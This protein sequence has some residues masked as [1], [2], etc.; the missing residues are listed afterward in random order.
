MLYTTIV[1]TFGE[2]LGDG[3]DV[4]ARFLDAVAFAQR[5]VRGIRAGFAQLQQAHAIVHAAMQRAVDSGKRTIE[6][7]TYVPW[8]SAYFAAGGANHPTE[9]VVFRAE[10]SWRHRLHSTRA[11]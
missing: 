4:D 11:Q 7:P 3:R 5:Y 9:F 8:K 6:L 10:D 1:G 2:D